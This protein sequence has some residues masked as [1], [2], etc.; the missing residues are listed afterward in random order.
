[1]FLETARLSLR[2]FTEDDAGLL[3]ALDSDPEVMRHL[4]AGPLGGQEAYQ[5][6]IRDRF[7]PY[8]QRYPNRGFWAAIEKTSGQFVG[9]F[10]LRPA[11]DYRLA[12]ELRFRADDVELGYRTHKGY[13]GKGYATEVSRALLAVAFQDSGVPFVVATTSVDNIASYR[14]MEKLGMRR[15]DGKFPLPAPY[16]P[17]LKYEISRQEFAANTYK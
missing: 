14:V 9:W 11:M 13:W 7:L 4:H 8:Y 5:K 1:M 17:A 3:L 12:A 16:P 15:V 10:V 6:Q 2:P